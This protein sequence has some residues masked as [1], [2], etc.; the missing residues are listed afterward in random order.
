MPPFT[1]LIAAM[2]IYNNYHRNVK[3]IIPI[4]K[5]EKIDFNNCLEKTWLFA[6]I[7]YG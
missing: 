6:K 1:L 4:E 7:I 5:N 3:Y 2:E